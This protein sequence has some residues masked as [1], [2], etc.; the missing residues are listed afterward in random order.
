MALGSKILLSVAVYADIS[1]SQVMSIPSD[2]LVGLHTIRHDASMISV[3]FLSALPHLRHSEQT[4]SADA[5]G[6][7]ENYFDTPFISDMSHDSN[8]IVPTDDS[9][10]TDFVTQ[11][12][13]RYFLRAHEDVACAT[14]VNHHHLVIFVSFANKSF[15]VVRNTPN[16]CEET[17]VEIVFISSMRWLKF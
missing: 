7:Q 8:G 5:V 16:V 10:D 17:N 2:L 13:I 6:S 12:Q 15:F 11:L 14:R 4:S 3:H 1:L 9:P